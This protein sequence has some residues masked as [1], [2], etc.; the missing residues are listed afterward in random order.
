MLM[1]TEDA[2]V[3]LLGPACNL[4][5]AA[6]LV[7]AEL[8]PMT[9]FFIDAKVEASAAT[10]AAVLETTVGSTAGAAFDAATGTAAGADAEALVLPLE[11]AACALEPLCCLR[12]FFFAATADFLFSCCECDH[13]LCAVTCDGCS[14]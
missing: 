8:L 10:P 1:A 4:P 14:R 13:E 9:G 11:A 12:F 5:D 6:A 7:P 3:A 2:A